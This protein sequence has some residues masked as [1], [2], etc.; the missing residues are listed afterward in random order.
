MNAERGSLDMV[1]Y[2]MVWY[3]IYGTRRSN[4]VEADG[5]LGRSFSGRLENRP[6]VYEA[7]ACSGK[8]CF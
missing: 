2:G 8:D 3:G 7:V 6:I 1:W 5:P 4:S